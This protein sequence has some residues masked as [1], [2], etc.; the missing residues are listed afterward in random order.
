MEMLLVRKYHPE[1]VNG[2]LWMAGSPVCKSIELPWRENARRISCIPEGTYRIHKRFSARF[3]WHFEI[4]G[5]P[6]R[7]AI[8]MHPA[9]DA[10][11][12]LQGCIAPVLQHTGAGRGISS[13]KALQRLKDLLYP[14]LDQEIELF[15]TIK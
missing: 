8:L 13:R 14:L 3:Q 9:N 2:V 12:E 10:T 5:V 7:S 6:G 11:R 1:G 4:A 15:I